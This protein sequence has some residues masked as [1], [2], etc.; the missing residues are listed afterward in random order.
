MESQR[1]TDTGSLS[2]PFRQSSDRPTKAVWLAVGLFLA[3]L[4]LISVGLGLW[5]TDPEAHGK[6]RPV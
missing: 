2:S 1:L 4:I 3:G 5:L 6:F